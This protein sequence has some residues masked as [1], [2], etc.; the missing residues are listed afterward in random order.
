[1]GQEVYEFV[2]E[3]LV[4]GKMMIDSHGENDVEMMFHTK[5]TS[6]HGAN[7]NNIVSVGKNEIMNQMMLEEY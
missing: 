6:I 7:H 5:F 2:M 1:M 3:K 4:N